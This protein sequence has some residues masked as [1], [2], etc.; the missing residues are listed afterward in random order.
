[1]IQD[2]IVY[3]IIAAVVAYVV[4]SMAFKKKKGRPSS[5]GG[6]TACSCELAQLKKD[7]ELHKK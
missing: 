3:I 7:C 6:C 2:I 5:C 4:W 1:M